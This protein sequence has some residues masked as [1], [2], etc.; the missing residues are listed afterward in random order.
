MAGRRGVAGTYSSL[1][2]LKA[3][4]VPVVHSFRFVFIWRWLIRF[5][6]TI[7]IVACLLAGKKP[8]EL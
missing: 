5:S 7:F 6:V 8:F 4:L 1:L 2:A 3:P